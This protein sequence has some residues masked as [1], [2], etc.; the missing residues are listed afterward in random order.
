MKSKKKMK[1]DA[2]PWEQVQGWKQVEV[3][4]EILVGNEH[5]GFMGLEEIDPTQIEGLDEIIGSTSHSEPEEKDK[6]PKSE[7]E[8]LEYIAKLERENKALKKESRAEKKKKKKEKVG[9]RKADSSD[10]VTKEVEEEKVLQVDVTAWKD[11]FL[12]GDVL[13]CIS[14]IGFTAPTQIQAECLPPAIRDRRDIIG[15][16]QTVSILCKFVSGV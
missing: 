6:G 10:E 5:F 4:D 13:R 12:P 11:F 7:S 9:K 16:A 15:A 14:R 1:N 2:D 3:G 8:L